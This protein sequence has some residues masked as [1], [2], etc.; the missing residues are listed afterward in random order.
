MRPVAILCD[1]DGTVAQED[2]GNLLFSEFTHDGEVYLF[3]DGENVRFTDPATGTAEGPTVTSTNWT[4]MPEEFNSGFDAAVQRDTDT[5]PT[6]YLKGNQFVRFTDVSAGMDPGYP[7]TI[8]DDWRG[9][10]ETFN[11]DIDAAVRRLSG[12]I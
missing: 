4:G 8:S 6:Y 10:P 1:F 7:R 3:N 9:M 12:V 5:D 11:S 2:V